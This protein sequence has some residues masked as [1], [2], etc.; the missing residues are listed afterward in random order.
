MLNKDTGEIRHIWLQTENDALDFINSN[1]ADLA[2][3]RKYRK[4]IGSLIYLM[5]CSRPDLSYYPSHV[6]NTG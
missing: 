6:N 5:T 3:L 4:I 2:D 1:T